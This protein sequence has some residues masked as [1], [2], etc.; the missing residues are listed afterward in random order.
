[1]RDAAFPTLA[2]SVRQP[3]AWAIICADKP[4][5]NRSH[6]AVRH[7]MPLL[8]PRA[9]HAAKGMTRAEYE[10]GRDFMRSLGIEC[11]APSE[12]LRG[13]IIGRVDVIDCGLSGPKT[14]TPWFHGPRALVLA[15][16]APCDF[17]P[18][19][20]ERGYFAW[21]PADAS[22]VPPPAKW[23]VPSTVIEAAAKARAK[24][25]QLDL[26]DLVQS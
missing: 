4:V 10:E 14:E 15:N 16:A 17:I 9:V 25:P 11:P 21:T 22:I 20:G 3:W 12:L 8:G 6:G 23:M 13:G 18:S 26:I 19:V 24:S 1:M 7:M 5:E 2:I